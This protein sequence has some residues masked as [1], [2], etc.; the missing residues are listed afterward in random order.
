MLTRREA[1]GSIATSPLALSAIASRADA[2][3]LPSSAIA[4]AVAA[5]ATLIAPNASPED[6][7]RDEAFWARVQ[8]AFTVDR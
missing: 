5:A 7:A 3:S 4:R 1:L 2:S 8:Q 6:V